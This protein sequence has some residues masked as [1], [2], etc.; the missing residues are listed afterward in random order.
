MGVDA[1]TDP[2]AFRLPAEYDQ[3][4]G[5]K[6]NLSLLVSFAGF[7]LSAF[8]Q[9]D[10]ARFAS[11]LRAKYGPPLARETFVARPGLEMVVDY[12]A[13]G[14]VCRIQLPPITEGREPGVKTVQAVNDFLMELVPMT[15]RGKQPAADGGSRRLALDVKYRIPKRH[16]L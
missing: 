10:G 3:A 13:N 4:M 14:H 7:A 8:A 16:H 12:A 5:V 6:A 9:I 1:N 11:D 15:M 2:Q